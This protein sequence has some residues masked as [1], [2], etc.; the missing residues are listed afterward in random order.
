MTAPAAGGF[1]G[2]S[3][4]PVLPITFETGGD[5]RVEVTELRTFAAVGVDV[6]Q[7]PA[8][9]GDID[10][11]PCVLARRAL[12]HQLPAPLANGPAAAVFP[13]QDAIFIGQLG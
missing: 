2:A 7:L 3:S 4:Q 11:H 8:V 1:G 9:G 5:V 13:A 12:A 10:R 6:V